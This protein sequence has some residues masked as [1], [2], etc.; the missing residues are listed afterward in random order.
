M[1]RIC[2]IPVSPWHRLKVSWNRNCSQISCFKNKLMA[3]WRVLRTQGG[4]DRENAKARAGAAPSSR[5]HGNPQHPFLYNFSVFL[6]PTYNYK[7]NIR[8]YHKKV[9]SFLTFSYELHFLAFISG[10][11]NTQ[12]ILVKRK[13]KFMVYI[14]FKF[15][16]LSPYIPSSQNWGANTMCNRCMKI[17]ILIQ[18][19]LLETIT[20]WS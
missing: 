19:K 1:E 11:Q 8:T 6:F 13:Q 9:H 14:Y 5:T 2:S 12:V 20:I 7:K 3:A 18:Q 17:T 10:L 16:H 15:Y 4:V